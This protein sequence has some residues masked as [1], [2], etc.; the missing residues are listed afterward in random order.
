VKFKIFGTIQEMKELDSY[1]ERR[2]AKHFATFLMACYLVGTVI[3]NI[4]LSSLGISEFDFVRLRYIFVGLVF[5]GISGVIPGLVFWFL[6]RRFATTRRKKKD[7]TRILRRWEAFFW[8]LLFPWIFLYSWWIFPAIPAGAGGGKPFLARPFGE[9][10]KILRINELIAFEMGIPSENLPFEL[11]T[12]NSK[13]AIGAN[14][15]VLDQNSDRA[16]LVLTPDLYLRSR[17][18]LA[19]DMLDSGEKIQTRQTQK[20]KEKP[21]LVRMRDIDGFTKTLYEPPDILTREDLAVAAAIISESPKQAKR[22]VAVA[23][24]ISDDLKR[25]ENLENLAVKI[26]TTTPA[27]GVEKVEA[28]EAVLGEAFGADFLEFRAKFFQKSLWLADFEKFHGQNLPERKLL[29]RE[30]FEGL[31]EEFPELAEADFFAD[32]V[33]EADFPRKLARMLRGAR[34]AREFVERVVAWRVPEVE[35]Q[36]G[37]GFSG[38]GTSF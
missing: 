10:S 2:G 38:S 31:S 37:S 16:L 13:L 24:R 32:G 33:R 14:V 12:K 27:P 23:E 8:I 22:V 30:I 35:L 4:H 19:G 34:D 5:A 36:S 15:R 26:A 20:W 18:K 9:Q 17:S 7:R 6:R 21:L 29:A 1:L 3:F 11:A 25:V 28:I